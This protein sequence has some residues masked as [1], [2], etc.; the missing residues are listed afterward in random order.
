MCEFVCGCVSLWSRVLLLFVGC[1]VCVYVLWRLSVWAGMSEVSLCTFECLCMN[2]SEVPVCVCVCRISLC[3]GVCIKGLC[4]CL[5]G[6][7]VCVCVCVFVCHLTVSHPC[8]QL[9]FLMAF[10]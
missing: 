4:V 10:V 2:V 3:V 5:C 6:V 8:H 7:C 1:V 9:S